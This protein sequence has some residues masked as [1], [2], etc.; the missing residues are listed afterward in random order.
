MVLDNDGRVMTRR[1]APCI[2]KYSANVDEKNESKQIKIKS[3][4]SHEVSVSTKSLFFVVQNVHS[5]FT[6]S[7][8][9]LYLREDSQLF[10]GTLG[11]IYARLCEVQSQKKGQRSEQPYRKTK[12]RLKRGPK[13]QKVRKVLPG[14]EPG[15]PEDSERYQNP[16]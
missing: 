10:L 4:A 16:E 9:S 3:I 7:S 14:I 8:G 5:T 11:K 2:C 6:E 1:H 12:K 15:L 13:G